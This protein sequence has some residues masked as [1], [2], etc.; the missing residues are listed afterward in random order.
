MHQ[1]DEIISDVLFGYNNENVFFRIAFSEF[2]SGDFS[3]IISLK[4]KEDDFLKITFSSGC[5]SLDNKNNI[6]VLFASKDCIDIRIDR[7]KFHNSIE[8]SVMT[9]IQAK[10]EIAKKIIYPVD[11]CFVINY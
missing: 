11:G 2:V 4:N 7:K 6:N 9:E 1:I 5:F 8:F 3:I 10:N